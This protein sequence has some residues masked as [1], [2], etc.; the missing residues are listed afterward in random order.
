MTHPVC[1]MYGHDW[2]T[3]AHGTANLPPRYRMEQ[4]SACGKTRT[5][6]SRSMTGGM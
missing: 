2:Q 5:V 6:M 4:C 3:D 1:K